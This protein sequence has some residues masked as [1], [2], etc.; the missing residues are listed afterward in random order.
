MHSLNGTGISVLGM[1]HR[2]P[3]FSS[4][5]D[6][7]ESILRELLGFDS[8]YSIAFMQ[9]G[10]TAQ[11]AMVPLLLGQSASRV[12]YLKTG[13]WSSKAVAEA[14]KF[15]PV[16]V[17]WDGSNSGFQRLPLEEEFECGADAAYLHYVSNETVEGLR[18]SYRPG[19]AGV[20]LVC[21]MSSD[22]C[23]GPIRIQDFDIIY[24]HA[25]KNLGP[26]GV[27]IAI[28]RRDLLDADLDDLPDTLDYRP[29]V[30][31]HSIYNTPPV[32]AIYATLLVLRWLRD[33]IGGLAN[34]EKIN[35]RKATMLYAALDCFDDCY[36][37]RVQL[38]DRSHMNV[39]FSLRKSEDT[40]RF[41]AAAESAGLHGLDGHRS[42]GGLRASLYN[43]VSE[44][45]VAAL[46]EFLENFRRKS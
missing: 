21:D 38:T 13:Y 35:Q 29:H 6:E 30:E 16:N 41:L 37:P 3:W 17:L 11:F 10:G 27:T 19:L 44:N 34:M 12:D 15:A 39:S 46:V 26:A 8:N 28:V 42:V 23:S 36:L 31:A 45:S 20:P 25:Q 9:G 2:S 18:F 7:A 5:V 33:D 24:A 1:S 43:A 32:F 22:F 14:S 4:V 40:P